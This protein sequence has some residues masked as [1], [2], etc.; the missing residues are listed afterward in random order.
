MICN[1]ILKA[2]LINTSASLGRHREGGSILLESIGLTPK[3]EG[4]SPIPALSGVRI[5]ACEE[6]SLGRHSLAR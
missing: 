3:I 5:H 2:L 4:N 1:K 6:T